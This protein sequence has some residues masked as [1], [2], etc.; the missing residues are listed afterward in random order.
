MP[1]A[2]LLVLHMNL[3]REHENQITRLI[4]AFL[5]GLSKLWGSSMKKRDAVNRIPLSANAEVTATVP[6]GQLH[7]QLPCGPVPSPA[8]ALCVRN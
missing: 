1:L 8:Q 3:A 6:K 5:T 7:C 2:V 4:F